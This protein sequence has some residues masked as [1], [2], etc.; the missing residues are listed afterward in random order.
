MNAV[1]RGRLALLLCLAA[2]SPLAWAVD[3]APPFADPV[4]QQRY[5]GLTHELRCVQCQ[6]GSIADSPVEI[7]AQL[8]REVRESI[9][10]GR[11]DDEIRDAMV[12]RYSEFVL[13]KPRWSGRSLLLWLL[14]GAL[15]LVG[16]G[17]G[18]NIIR[19]RAQLLPVDDSVVDEE[20]RT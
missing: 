17:V 15:L 8:R 7:A 18:V 16:A 13:L 4:L 1:V 9:A 3:A 10:A 14:P 6:N 19:R 5:L 11:T 2:L 12:S 20:G